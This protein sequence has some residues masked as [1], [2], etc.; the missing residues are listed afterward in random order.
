[1]GNDSLM[2]GVSFYGDENILE[3]NRLYIVV[4]VLIAARF[5]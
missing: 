3:L 2:D 5:S 4:N 1:M